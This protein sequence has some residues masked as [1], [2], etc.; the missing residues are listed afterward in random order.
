[1]HVDVDAW[2]KARLEELIALFH[3]RGAFPSGAMVLAERDPEYLT[4]LDQPMTFEQ[5]KSDYA[6][7]EWFTQALRWHCRRLGGL[8]V[9]MYGEMVVTPHPHMDVSVR[10]FFMSYARRG[11]VNSTL[12][13]APIETADG[14]PRL[15][16]LEECVFEETDRIFPVTN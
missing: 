4:E 5:A 9:V 11:Y 15:A 7:A 1:M 6:T 12:W 14:K 16:S 10:T 3:Q 8:A 2:A 13:T